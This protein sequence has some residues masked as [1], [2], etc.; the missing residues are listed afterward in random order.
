MNLSLMLNN[1]RQPFEESLNTVQRL[2]IP[3]I[4]LS[5]DG[6]WDPAVCDTTCRKQL[7][8]ALDGRGLAISA[9][10]G[11]GRAIDLGQPNQAKDNIATAQKA[12]EMAADLMGAAGVA[13]IWQDHVG[14]IP[15]SPDG[16]R[17]DSFVRCT[18]AIA[19]HGEK[20]GACLAVETGPEPAFAVENL[21]RTV[22]S[23]ALRVN[24][25]PANLIL[26]PA[27]FRSDPHLI[28]KF[29]RPAGPYEKAAAFREF[30]PIEGVRR[31]GRFIVHTHAK[32]ALVDGAVA[33]EVPLGMGWV[34]WPRYLRLL[35]QVGYMG[36][37]AIERETG[38]DP[39][40]DI[41]QAAA[42]LREQLQALE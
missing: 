36:Y 15:S 11:C 19:R 30:E 7:R 27:L 21:L 29:G 37:L 20:V 40:G 24:Y 14:V 25:D 5:A 23:T 35:K 3:A 33:R 39:V 10:S 31:L 28:E 42:F 12:L 13:G 6:R 41:A 4:H 2:K 34:D 18:Q 22:G 1:L 26:Y 8:S 17:W 32:D 9:L 16:P 38:A